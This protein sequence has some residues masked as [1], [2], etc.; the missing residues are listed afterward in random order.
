V[1][2]FSFPDWAQNQVTEDRRAAEIKRLDQQI[3]EAE[4]QIDRDRK[5]RSHHFEVRPA[6]P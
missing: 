6:T 2:L 3:A 4:A 5:P 1:Q